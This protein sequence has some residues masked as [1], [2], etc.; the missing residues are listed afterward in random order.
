MAARK[1]CHLPQRLRRLP[2]ARLA[3]CDFA[4]A[5]SAR[6]RFRSDQRRNSTST[7]PNSNSSSDRQ[8]APDADRLSDAEYG[9]FLKSVHCDGP[10]IDRRS[11]SRRS[12]DWTARLAPIMV[13]LGTTAAGLNGSARFRSE[14]ALSV[15]NSDVHAGD[16]PACAGRL[17]TTTPYHLARPERALQ[18]S[19]RRSQPRRGLPHR[20]SGIL[21]RGRHSH[22]LLW[23]ADTVSLVL[24]ARY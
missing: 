2:G 15:D 6:P 19:A 14:H 10:T 3:Y 22:G 24:S 12:P 18:R 5:A 8:S 16:L 21:I 1:P 7:A 20:R 17:L 9:E 23:R 13:N 11:K 4:V